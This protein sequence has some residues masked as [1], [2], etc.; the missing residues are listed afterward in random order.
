MDEHCKNCVHHNN[1]RHPKEH[2]NAT[3]HNNWCCYYSN[4]ADR[5]V[6]HC[7]MHSGKQVALSGK[8]N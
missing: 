5:V 8:E 3:R 2:P 7:K 6:G 1:A 4:R